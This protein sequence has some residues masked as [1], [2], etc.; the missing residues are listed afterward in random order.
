VQ[1]I[2]DSLHVLAIGT[3]VASKPRNWLRAFGGN[4]CAKDLPARARQPE[5]RNQPI[6]SGQEEAV[7]PEQVEDEAGQ[8]FASRS[9]LG[10]AHPSP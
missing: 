7:E 1:V 8:G 3:H 9:S 2:D 10:F 4:H 6:A 5:P